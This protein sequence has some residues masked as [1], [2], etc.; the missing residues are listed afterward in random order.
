MFSYRTTEASCRCIHV[1]I[2]VGSL[3][4]MGIGKHAQYQRDMG[5]RQRVILIE[6]E[7]GGEAELAKTE[8]DEKCRGIPLTDGGDGKEK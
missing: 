7:K 5:K 1:A 6:G 8:E 4:T 3:A 2:Y